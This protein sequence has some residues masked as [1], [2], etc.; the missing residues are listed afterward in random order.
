MIRL[1]ISGI[2]G[3]M[4]KRIAVLA[5][6]DKDFE[7]TGALEAP[8]NP[9]AGKDIG[10]VAGI[11]PI[12]RKVE[13]DFDKAEGGCDVLIEFTAPDATIT[14]LEAAVR[15]GAAMVIGTTALS[16]GQIEKVRRASERIRMAF[17]RNIGWGANLCSGSRRR[18]P[19][20]W[21]AIMT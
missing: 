6:G 3:R 18:S 21:A 17:P 9:S 19:G 7:I 13:P 16:P 10:D 15:K 4:G 1:V 20:R 14:H 8:D 2:G 11:G 5:S 12:G